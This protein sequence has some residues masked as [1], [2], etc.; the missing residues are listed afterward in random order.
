MVEKTPRHFPEDILYDEVSLN[1]PNQSTTVQI[2]QRQ[3]TFNV[4]SKDYES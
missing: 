2:F 4:T 1:L 3:N